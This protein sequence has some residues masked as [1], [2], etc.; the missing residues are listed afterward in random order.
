ML[1]NFI[2]SDEIEKL[3]AK[4]RKVNKTL[5]GTVKEE[6]ANWLAK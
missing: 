5:N 2:W 3:A 4:M 6:L 1:E